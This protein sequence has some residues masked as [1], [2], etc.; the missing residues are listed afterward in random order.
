MLQFCLTPSLSL[1]LAKHFDRDPDTNEVLWFSA[2]PTNIARA[3]TPKHS[4]T[5]LHYL[6]MKR[7]RETDKAVD[8]GMDVHDDSLPSRRK[9][10]KVRPTVTEV[11]TSVLADLS[12]D[13]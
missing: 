2:P 1:F 13:M 4:L 9:L 8:D 10:E 5:Y 3:P 6:A 11:V 12:G 7:K